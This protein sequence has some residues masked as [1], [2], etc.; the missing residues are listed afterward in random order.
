MSRIISPHRSTT[1]L[2]ILE[3][4]ALGVVRGPA[5]F[6]VDKVVGN[7]TVHVAVVIVPCVDKGPVAVVI[8]SSC[9]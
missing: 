6:V 7:D 4:L 1:A 8:V 3:Y 9:R 2:H 5:T